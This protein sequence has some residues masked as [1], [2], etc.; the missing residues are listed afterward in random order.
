[1]G[2]VIH[3]PAVS[4]RRVRLAYH[5]VVW[6]LRRMPGVGEPSRRPPDRPCSAAGVGHGAGSW[7]EPG[8]S[9]VPITEVD[10]QAATVRPSGLDELDRVL[11]GGLVPGAVVLL[12]GEPGVGKSTLLLEVTRSPPESGTVLYVT[13]EESAAQVRLRADRIGSASGPVSTSRPRPELSALLAHVE[14]VRPQLLI[15]DSVQIHH[16]TR[17]RREPPAG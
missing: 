14:A 5:K 4:L 12:A 10:S 6:A 13:G 2:K 7:R 11:G 9:A 1:M 15:V 3:R 8:R 16:R 17:R